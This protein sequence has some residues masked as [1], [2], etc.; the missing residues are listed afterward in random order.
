MY[1][2]RI[3]ARQVGEDRLFGVLQQRRGSNRVH[4]WCMC[5]ERWVLGSRGIEGL[6]RG[7]SPCSWSMVWN[8]VVELRNTEACC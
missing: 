3:R 5:I 4:S 7:D 6:L 8:E 1:P 2:C